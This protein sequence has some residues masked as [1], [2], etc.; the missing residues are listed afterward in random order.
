MQLVR[1]G[2]LALALVGMSAPVFA[3][4]PAFNA[5]GTDVAPAQAAPAEPV[6]TAPA[7]SGQAGPESTPLNA[8]PPATDALPRP[9][10]KLEELIT[11]RVRQF[12]DRK[13]EQA[14]VE[15]FY[16][17]RAFKPLW[18]DNGEALARACQ[19]GFRRPRLP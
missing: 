9:V 12:V 4:T 3:Q 11:T 17:D 8:N 13:P 14:A 19:G 18:S 10:S 5:D 16:R 7:E 6:Q 15:A 1:E 2:V